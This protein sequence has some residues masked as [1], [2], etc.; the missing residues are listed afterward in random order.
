[1]VGERRRPRPPAAQRRRQLRARPAG[2][3]VGRHRVRAHLAG[4]PEALPQGLP[5]RDSPAVDT[6]RPSTPCS[7]RRAGASPVPRPR[8]GG[9]CRRPAVRA[10]GAGGLL[11]RAAERNRPPGRG[12]RTLQPAAG[13]RSALHWP[14]CEPPRPGRTCAAASPSRRRPYDRAAVRRRRTRRGPRPGDVGPGPRPGAL[15]RAPARPQGPGAGPAAGRRRTTTRSQRTPG[16]A[17]CAPG[18]RSPTRWSP[19]RRWTRSC[20]RGRAPSPASSSPWCTRPPRA[21]PMP[22]TPAS[23]PCWGTARR[24]TTAPSGRPAGRSSCPAPSPV[25]RPSGGGSG[26]CPGP[27]SGARRSTSPAPASR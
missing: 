24:S 9:G 25:W 15:R 13:G 11:G 22:S 2:G 23:T 14:P 4:D 7:L 26:P 5:A 20:C 1:M 21:R 10:H 16:C 6:V 18:G 19:S 3:P 17:R 12:F 8:P 27:T